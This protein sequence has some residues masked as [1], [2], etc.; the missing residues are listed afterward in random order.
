MK[1]LHRGGDH[2]EMQKTENMKRFRRGDH[3]EMPKKTVDAGASGGG[4]EGITCG[5]GGATKGLG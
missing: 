4:E 1:R 3:P 2:P 5:R